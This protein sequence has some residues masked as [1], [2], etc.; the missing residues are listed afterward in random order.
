M[1]LQVRNEGAYPERVLF[2]WARSYSSSL[3]EGQDYSLLPRTIVISIVDFDMFDCPA[4]HSEFR[5]LETTRHTPLSDRMSLHFFE[6]RKLPVGL[7]KDNMLVLWLALFKAETE[8][9]LSMINALEVPI[10]QEAI[11]AYRQTSVSAEFKELERMR[12]KARH[13]EAQALRH[14]RQEGEEC[15][16][17]RWQNVVADKDAEIARLQALLN[18]R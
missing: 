4:F 6:L 8:E 13:D 5:P 12:Q 2:N 16:N 3:S 17:I 11:Q 18:Q 10:M 9:E 1:R 15:A 14:A 7:A